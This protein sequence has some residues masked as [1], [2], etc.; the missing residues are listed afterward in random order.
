MYMCFVAAKFM[1]VAL[2]INGASIVITVTVLMLSGGDNSK[3]PPPWLIG[4]T[5]Q[6]AAAL[7]MSTMRA[8]VAAD[9]DDAKVKVELACCFALGLF[10]NTIL[11]VQ[12]PI[13]MQTIFH[14]GK[15]YFRYFISLLAEILPVDNVTIQIKK[16]DFN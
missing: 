12:N 6:I 1:Y 5:R 16:N 8:R 15:V 10:C 9:E 2:G 14:L 13:Y 11:F 7:R 4:G 3:P